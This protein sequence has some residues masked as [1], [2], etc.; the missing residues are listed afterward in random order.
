MPPYTPYIQVLSLDTGISGCVH[1]RLDCVQR[2][3]AESWQY[4]VFNAAVCMGT[5]ILQNPRNLLAP[6]AMTLINSAITLYTSIVQSYSTGRLVKNLEW[7]L[8]LRHRATTRMSAAG[9]DQGVQVEQHSDDEEDI[10]LLGWRT[11]LVSRIGRGAQTAVTITP[12]QSATTPSPNTA[13]A[14]TIT[15]ALQKHFVP[16]EQASASRKEMIGGGAPNQDQATDNLV[17]EPSLPSGAR[18]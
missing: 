8:K 6:L 1:A 13:M 16:E 2:P 10:E 9:G 4:H 3:R 18:C 15:H 11:R 17:I 7:L 12:T 14:R 5:L